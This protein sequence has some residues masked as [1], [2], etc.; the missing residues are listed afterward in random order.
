MTYARIQDGSV[1]EY[2]VFEGDIKLRY[3]NVSFSIP[4]EP[5]AEFVPVQ[6]VPYPEV[7]Y[8]KQVTAATPSLI[9]DTWF[10]D[11]IISD[12][13]PEII[14][15]RTDIKAKS[16][17]GERNSRLSASDWTQFTD[18]PLTEDKKIAWAIYRQELRDITKQA[19]FPWNVVWPDQPAA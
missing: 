7:D 15:E 18:S 5:P 12:A 19:G 13:S 11:W 17:R 8:T 3:P 4:F 2:P 9:G 6:V 16:V 14:A 1:A 10:Q